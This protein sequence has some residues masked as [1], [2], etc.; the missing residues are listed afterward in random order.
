VILLTYAQIIRA[1]SRRASA[2][3]TLW[4]QNKNQEHDIEI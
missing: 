4:A 3:P 1:N 2:S